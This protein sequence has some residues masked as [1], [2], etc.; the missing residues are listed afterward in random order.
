MPNADDLVKGRF[1]PFTTEYMEAMLMVR[2]QD[3][4]DQGNHN[5]ADRE[6]LTYAVLAVR[7]LKDLR[8]RSKAPANTSAQ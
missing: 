3:I 6:L 2:I 7:E 5:Q 4:L 8:D 1:L